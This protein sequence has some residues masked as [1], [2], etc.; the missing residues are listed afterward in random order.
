MKKQNPK[1]NRLWGMA[2]DLDKCT[3]CGECAVSCAQENN[4]PI[5]KD[6]SLVRRRV[7]L[8]ELL[9]VTNDREEKYPNVKTA[10]LPKMCQ[11]CSGE[12][13]NDATPPCLNAC[14]VNAIDV[15]DDGVVGLAHQRCTGCRSCMAACPFNAI[16]FNIM[17]PQHNGFEKSL[18]P[19]VPIPARGTSTK[20]TFC[21]HIWRREREKAAALGNTDINAVTYKTA[22][23][24][25]CPTGAIVF[26]DLNDP[27]SEVSRLHKDERALPLAYSGKVQLNTKVRYLTK[28]SWLKD[29]MTFDSKR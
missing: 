11:H 6:D 29:M 16:A 14:P 23:A 28:A 24:A 9:R 8:L 1:M 19:D 22:C 17:K 25:A 27:E 13:K 4:M 7:A 26:G 15:G 12:D 20:C 21:H 2:I 5:P 10:F 18:N 3:G